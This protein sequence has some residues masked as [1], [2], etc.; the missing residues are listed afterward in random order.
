MTPRVLQLISTSGFYGAER[1][2]LELS[3]YLQDRGWDT[4]VGVLDSPGAEALLSRARALALP[5]IVFPGAKV[6][7]IRTM[8]IIHRYAREHGVALIHTHGYKSDV[9]QLL[10]TLS[11]EVKH[12]ATC[13]TW[14]STNIKLKLYEHLDKAVL[15]FFHHVVVV[16]PQLLEDVRHSGVSAGR[17]SLIE[18]GVTLEPLSPGY[19]REEQRRQWG[20]TSDEL[21][22]LRV[23][24]LDVPK[25]NDLLLWA[26]R[27]ALTRLPVR[28]VLAG[29][30]PER[31]P[32]TELCRK[33]GIQDR[34]VFTGYQEHISDLL[35]AADLF[36][37]SSHK[38]GLPIV[39]IEAMA[40]G[41]PVVTTDVG[42]IRRLIQPGRTGWLVPPGRPELLSLALFEALEHPEQRRRLAEAA[43]RLYLDHHSRDA[44]GQQYLEIYQKLLSIPSA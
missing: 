6:W 11:D 33:L 14:Y 16:S 22:I 34:V 30:G 26:A 19:S 37:I 10:S 8:Q 44:M 28:L 1:V 39:L 2:L 32:L 17:S 15:R 25:G 36:V 21:V 29:D 20:V 27:S 4:T 18:N 7:P 43:H 3:L 35:Q 24:R 40:A 38:E 9:L 5:T 31:G 42:A 41:L 23:G 12:V 13:H